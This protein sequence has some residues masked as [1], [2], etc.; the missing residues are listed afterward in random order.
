MSK[1]PFKNLGMN[2]EGA[3]NWSCDT[4]T[5]PYV[6]NMLKIP[7]CGGYVLEEL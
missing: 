1:R 5:D 2:W 6:L 4:W 7:G 3:Q